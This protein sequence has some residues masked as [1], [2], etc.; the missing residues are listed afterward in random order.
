MAAHTLTI[1]KQM[2]EKPELTEKD[3]EQMEFACGYAR[4]LDIPLIQGGYTDE[5]RWDDWDAIFYPAQKRD[6]VTL[7]AALEAMKSRYAYMVH[8][9]MYE[10]VLDAMD[11]YCGKWT[12]ETHDE[13]QARR[14]SFLLLPCS[15]HVKLAAASQYATI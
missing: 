8:Y 7:R 10:H 15:E 3:C 5:G 1:I 9:R 14:A 2:L 13:H 4:G 12:S 11:T 6:G